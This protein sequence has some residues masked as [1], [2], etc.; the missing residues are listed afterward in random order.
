MV[1]RM[2]LFIFSFIFLYS[3]LVESKVI[4][5]PDVD[6]F[7]IEDGK[8][9]EVGE[10]GKEGYWAG[11]YWGGSLEIESTEDGLRIKSPSSEKNKSIRYFKF[12]PEYP[13]LVWE[14]TKVNYGQGY[15]AIG[16]H[17]PTSVFGF[18]TNI[19]PGIFVVNPFLFNKELK[20]ETKPCSIYLYNTEVYLKY[21][22]MVKQPDNYIEIESAD[23]EKKG[24]LEEG[25]EVLFRVK[26]KE[27][28]EDAT[29]TFYH[30][31]G[32]NQVKING[33]ET[34]QLKPEDEEQKVWTAK[35]KIND[36]GKGRLSILK[37]TSYEKGTFLIK[38]TILGGEI[39]VPLWTSNWFEIKGSVKK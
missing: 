36:I 35:I 30:S 25:D 12:S 23:I 13:Y 27:S 5:N 22:K 14:I 33:S 34:L 17:F 24:Y 20:E 2:I 1:K 3:L 26:L 28:C 39:K 29:L 21:I 11:K 38:A 9:V 10:V 15:R 18:V 4:Y 8:E 32:T 6:T 37:K 19:Y 31:Y 7:W 16:F